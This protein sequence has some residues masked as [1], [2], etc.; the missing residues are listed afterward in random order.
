MAERPGQQQVTAQVGAEL[1]SL[2]LPDVDLEL[3]QLLLSRVFGSAAGCRADH[4][5]RRGGDGKPQ[6]GLLPELVELLTLIRD[7]GIDSAQ[8]DAILG[9]GPPET[10]PVGD[11]KPGPEPR[12]SIQ[13]LTDQ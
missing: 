8:L 9:A 13:P 1:I 12:S 4:G 11:D 7:S 5:G 3:V 2:M 10:L 6:T